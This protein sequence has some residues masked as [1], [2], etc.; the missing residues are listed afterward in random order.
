VQERMADQKKRDDVIIAH[1]NDLQVVTCEVLCAMLGFEHTHSTMNIV[2][3]RL[4]LLAEEDGRIKHFRQVRQDG[5]TYTVSLSVSLRKNG[6]RAQLLHRAMQSRFWV[7]LLRAVSVEQRTTDSDFHAEGGTLVPDGFFVAD[8][9]AFFVECD[10]GRANFQHVLK[11]AQEY[12]KQQEYLC[13]IHNIPTFRVLWVT[14]F[15]DERTRHML[16]KFAEIGGGELCLVTTEEHFSPFEPQTILDNWFSPQSAVDPQT[17]KRRYPKV[18][19]WE[20][21]VCARA[22]QAVSDTPVSNHLCLVDGPA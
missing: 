3:R 15:A 13:K 17:G 19:L 18:R 14:R 2:E 8:G 5:T 20:G 9:H 10:T 1:V 7:T 6:A 11:K 22:A 21:V 4:R 16:K 12:H